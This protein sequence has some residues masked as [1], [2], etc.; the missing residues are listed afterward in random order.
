[1]EEL[2]ISLTRLPSP[3]LHPGTM[4]RTLRE[5]TRC[6]PFSFSYVGS[7]AG[8]GMSIACSF[9]IFFPRLYSWTFTIDEER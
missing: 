2:V 4:A 5:R 3:S 9:P 8:E 6:H 1:M 7:R